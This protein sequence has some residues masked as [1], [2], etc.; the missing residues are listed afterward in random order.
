MFHSEQNT[1]LINTISSQIPSH[2]QGEWL[3]HSS[4]FCLMHIRQ[5]MLCLINFLLFL[6]MSTLPL[7]LQCLSFTIAEVELFCT[8]G[9][10]SSYDCAS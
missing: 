1:S 9:S 2:F 6:I 10:N 7:L 3:Y 5:A 4:I 8:G